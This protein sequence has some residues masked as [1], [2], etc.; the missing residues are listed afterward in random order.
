MKIK[1]KYGECGCGC[2][3]EGLI[4]H[5]GLKLISG[6]Y[7]KH[8]SKKYAERRR[9][10]VNSGEKA[11]KS[12]LSSFYKQVWD[13]QY[14]VC[15]ETNEPLFTYHKWH[16]HHVLHK[17]DYPELAFNKDICVLLT[18]EQHSTWH[19]LAKSDRARKMPRT[20]SRYL[21]LCETY[22]LAP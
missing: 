12:K 1:Y 7:Q 4:I 9:K 15:F 16:V 14:H 20:W 21:Q 13:S 5:K 18:L 19:Q 2:G 10:R 3:R 22:N 17:E 8:L 6:C 11:D